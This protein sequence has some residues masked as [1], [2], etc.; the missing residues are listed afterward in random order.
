M[1]GKRG[2]EGR[3]AGDCPGL[4]SELPRG[5]GRGIKLYHHKHK[6][7]HTK[8]ATIKGRNF[9]MANDES[10]VGYKHRQKGAG[11]RQNHFTQDR[12]RKKC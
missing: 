7:T 12:L 4:P 1:A 6:H 11:R 10:V 2:G 9:P 3:G 5:C 8:R